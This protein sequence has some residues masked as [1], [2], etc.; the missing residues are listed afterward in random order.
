MDVL[1]T[2][3]AFNL[4]IQLCTAVFQQLT[5]AMQHLSF[6]KQACEELADRILCLRGPLQERAQQLS[7]VL[8]ARV[9]KTLRGIEQSVDRYIAKAYFMKVLQADKYR[10]K[11]EH[12]HCSIG[13]LIDDVK[14]LHAISGACAPTATAVAWSAPRSTV[15]Q[16]QIDAC[17]ALHQRSKPSLYSGVRLSDAHV[18]LITTGCTWQ[19][20]CFRRPVL[21]FQPSNAQEDCT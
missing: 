1:A 13:R 11:F 21:P 16:V 9:T 2:Q 19:L 5:R 3:T 17:A 8:V 4:V 18:Q 7:Q 10:H 20:R 15:T 6:N 12:F 14:N